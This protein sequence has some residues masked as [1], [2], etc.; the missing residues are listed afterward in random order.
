MALELCDA[1]AGTAG[2]LI[3]KKTLAVL[4][5]FC[6][7]SFARFFCSVASGLGPHLKVRFNSFQ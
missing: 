1:P 2:K 4:R 3:Q 5:L 6:F 7:L